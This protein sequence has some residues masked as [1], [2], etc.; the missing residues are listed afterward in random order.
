MIQRRALMAVAATT[1]MV[2]ANPVAPVSA[3]APSSAT[4]SAS[5]TVRVKLKKSW[6]VMKAKQLKVKDGSMT[7]K[8]TKLVRKKK[9]PA[10]AALLRCALPDGAVAGTTLKLTITV[11][12]KKGAK[13]RKNVV[14]LP[15]STPPGP[16]PGDAATRRLQA[17]DLGRADH[18]RQLR[19]QRQRW[20]PGGR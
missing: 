6:R 12:G 3:Q 4:L 19:R 15:S 5:Q 2:L 17:D 18:A 1:A 16:G 7:C 10:K 14:V 13:V 11:K 8:V 20:Q 9:K